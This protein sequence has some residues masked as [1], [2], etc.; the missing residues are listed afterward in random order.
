MIVHTKPPSAPASGC[1]LPPE[2]STLCGFFFC[3]L[4]RGGG[5]CSPRN[6]QEPQNDQIP[7]N[8]N[9]DYR[10]AALPLFCTLHCKKTVQCV[11]FFK[12]LSVFKAIIFL[13]FCASG[14]SVFVP[15]EFSY[16]Q[17]DFLLLL[18]FSLASLFKD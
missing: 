14:V 8:I 15:K 2:K 6:G 9:R 11:C 4:V 12:I 5:G 16:E 17:L 3:C 18:F 10:A 7:R 1:S 13:Y